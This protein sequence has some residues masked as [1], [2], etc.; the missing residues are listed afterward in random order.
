MEKLDK[1]D[2]IAG[3]NRLII[4]GDFNVPKVDWHNGELMSRAQPIER[5]VL[6]VTVDCLWTQHVWQHT[7]F[8]GDL[9]STLDLIFTKEEEDI[10]NIE[11]L[12]PLGS[13]DHGVVIADFVCEWKSK[14][15]RKPRR[16]YHKGRYEH[17]IE[18]LNEV[19][20]DME[21]EGKAVQECWEI[22]KNKLQA[23]V[24]EHIPMSIPKEYNEPWMNKKLIKLWRK[25]YF[26]WKRFTERKI[27]ERYREYKNR[28]NRLKKNSRKTKRSYE[29]KLASE[30][31]HNRRA[32]FR[33]V[34]SKLTVRPELTEVQN[35]NGELVDTEKDMCDIVGK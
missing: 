14:I 7:R 8:R 20:W 1:A 25:K 10:K 29:K 32:F 27:Y 24:E 33:Y 19:D 18:G 11:V 4:L 9:S 26:A 3:D 5:K 2:E 28:A 13:S 17:I 22:F 15:V 23:L 34:N 6:E 12:P 30:V 21:F 35:E 16:M 31:R